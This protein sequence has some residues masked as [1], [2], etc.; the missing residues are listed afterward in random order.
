M[1][2]RSSQPRKQHKARVKSPLHRRNQELKTPLDKNRYGSSGVKRATI[3]KGDHVKVVRGSRTGLEGKI[4]IVD[5]KKR[6]VAIEKALIR[7]ADNKEVPLWFDPSNLVITKLDLSDAARK[8]RFK[9][10]SEE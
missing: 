1:N 6:K 7:K 9:S 4:S 8:E 5:L 3:R 2:T 10:L